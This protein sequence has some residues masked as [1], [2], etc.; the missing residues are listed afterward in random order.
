MSVVAQCQGGKMEERLSLLEARHDLPGYGVV[1]D[2][3]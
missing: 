1:V 3:M 2:G